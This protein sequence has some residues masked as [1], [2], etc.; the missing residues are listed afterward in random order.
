MTFFPGQVEFFLGGCSSEVGVWGLQVSDRQLAG[1]RGAIAF[2]GGAIT[3][4]K[5]T[6]AITL[7]MKV[8]SD[9]NFGNCPCDR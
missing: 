5:I 9:R 8:S 3:I 7:S 4:Q 6:S 1:R 2:L